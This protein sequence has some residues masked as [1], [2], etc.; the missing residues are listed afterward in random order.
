MPKTTLK[1]RLARRVNHGS[2][3]GPEP[4]LMSSEENELVSFQINACK[5]G[6]G[7]TKREVIDVVRKTVKKEGKGG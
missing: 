7:K 3:S 2:K 5:M 6:H 1:D 4:Y